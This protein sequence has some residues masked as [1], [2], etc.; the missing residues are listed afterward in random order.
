MA[1]SNR[2]VRFGQRNR[3]AESL[4]SFR[5]RRFLTPFLL[6]VLLTVAAG[7]SFSAAGPSTAGPNS[8]PSKE[9]PLEGFTEPYRVVEVAAAE[10]GVLTQI[11]VD[12]GDRVV[13]GQPVAQLDDSVI[14]AA[15]EVVKAEAESQGRLQS[16]E[17]DLELQTDLLAKLEQLL[18]QNHASALEVGRAA[19]QKKVLAA[20][21]KA[22]REELFVKSCEVRRIEA[23]IRQR[24]VRAPLDGV[25]TRTLKKPGEFVS[26]SDAV[27]VK[28]AQLDPLAVTFSVPV[29]MARKFHKGQTVALD[30]SIRGRNSGEVEFVSPVADVQSGTVRMRVRLANPDESI[31]AGV[32]CRLLPAADEAAPGSPIAF[33]K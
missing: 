27:V 26:P 28:L 12:E 14:R 30:L 6:A 33:T 1:K 9:E 29:N 22:V 32:H 5:Q 17:A 21:V 8:S 10:M 15:L 11:S 19:T 23:Q 4:P 2:S 3:S 24:C 16:A 7:G 31:P 13:A 20:R 18:E 25:V